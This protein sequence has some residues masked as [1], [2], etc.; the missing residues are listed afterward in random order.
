M[1]VSWPVGFPDVLRAGYGYDVPDPMLSA[2]FVHGRRQRL[3]YRDMGDNFGQLTLV[4][5]YGAWAFWR[6]WWKYDLHDGT[7]WFLMPLIAAG[8][9]ALREARFIGIYIPT[10]IPEAAGLVRFTFDVETRVGTAPE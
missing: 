9:R 7:E 1:A 5:S 3:L 6:A 4:V 2:N 10:P 8:T